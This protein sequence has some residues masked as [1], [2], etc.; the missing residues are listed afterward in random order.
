[1]NCLQFLYNFLIWIH[2]F[3]TIFIYFSLLNEI[4]IL[5]YSIYAII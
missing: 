1:M 5:E 3:T 2:E 4:I